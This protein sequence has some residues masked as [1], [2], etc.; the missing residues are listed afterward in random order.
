MAAKLAAVLLAL[1]GIGI[2]GLAVWEAIALVSGDN[3]SI[4]SAVALIVLTAAGAAL[5]VA[6]AVAVWRGQSWGRS[7]GIV[8]QLLILAVALG[9][10]TGIYGDG[11]T[12][13]VIAVPALIT[14]VLLVVAVRD[15]GRRESREGGG[16]DAPPSAG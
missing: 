15:A 5:V 13:L 7:G 11:A 8:T 14:L 10:A 3:V 12:A 2:I 6:F 16:P 4:V 1:E 9:A